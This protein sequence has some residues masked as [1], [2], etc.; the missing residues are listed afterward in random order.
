VRQADTYHPARLRFV[1]RSRRADRQRCRRPHHGRADARAARQSVDRKYRGG[2]GGSIGVARVAL[3]GALRLTPSTNRPVGH[4]C[5]TIIY[6]FDYDLEKDFE[7]IASSPTI[8]AAD[9]R[10]EQLPAKTSHLR[11]PGLSANPGKINFGQPEPPA[12]KVSGVLFEN[13]NP[14]EIPVHSLSCAG[15]A[16]DR[17]MSGTVTCW[18]CRRGGWPLPN[19]RRQDQ[20]R[21]ANLSAKRS[22]SMP[23]Y[24]TRGRRP[25]CPDCHGGIVRLLCAE[26]TPKDIIVANSI[27]PANVERCPIPPPLKKNGFGAGARMCSPREQQTAEGL[28]RGFPEGRKSTMVADHQVT[29]IGAHAQIAGKRSSN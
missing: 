10:Q 16:M 23:G 22:A 11:E 24:P 6:N 26:G 4:P 25:A 20:G 17:L 8:P 2:H 18:S 21:L 3:A 19:P 12:R 29:G 28:W 27:M 9:V 15:P 14:T 13:L 7:P 5:R 1:V